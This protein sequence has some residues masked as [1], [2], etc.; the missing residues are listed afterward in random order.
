MYFLRKETP[1]FLLSA[2]RLF[3]RRRLKA[4]RGFDSWPL[5]RH[6]RPERASPQKLPWPERCAGGT[7]PTSMMTTR[8][9][10]WRFRHRRCARE[11]R[12][13]EMN[14]RVERRRVVASR[15]GGGIAA[16]MLGA[17]QS[18]ITELRAHRC[19]AHARICATRKR[20]AAIRLAQYISFST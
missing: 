2:S 8:S 6:A 17:E 13:G 14:N 5:T 9:S 15:I 18:R 19:F 7:P 16:G 1:H 20:C 3:P 10:R 11:K 4:V 12:A